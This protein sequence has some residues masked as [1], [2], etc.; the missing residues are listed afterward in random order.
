[1]LRMASEDIRTG[2]CVCTCVL[3]PQTV[4]CVHV[5]A[6]MCVDHV[7]VYQYM[8]VHVYIFLCVHV[9]CMPMHTYM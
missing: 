2:I 1:M 5:C 9:Y 3:T 6:Y 4:H 7:W 8:H